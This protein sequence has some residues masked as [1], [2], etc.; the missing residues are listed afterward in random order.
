MYV[1]FSKGGGGMFDKVKKILSPKNKALKTAQ[2]TFSPK[3]IAAGFGGKEAKDQLLKKSGSVGLKSIAK[4]T[5]T[6]SV[7][8]VGA[9]LGAKAIGKSI[10]KKIP[11]VGLLAGIGFGLQR[12]MKGDFAGAALE[13]ASGAVSLVPGVGTAASI[14]I[15]AGL[16]AKDI[17]SASS[18]GGTAADF[19][20]RPGQPIQ[21]FR[22]DDI[23]VG[24]T[25]LSG[26]G[27]NNSEVVSLLQELLLEVKKGG[28]VYMDGNKVGRSLALATSNMG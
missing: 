23:I 17:S 22:K 11:G 20:S 6:K 12:A 8:K 13:L 28:N 9:K 25:S 24:G 1:R 19:I 15:D 2:K 10:L 14:A 16:A 26:G 27:G 18:G 7:A 5:G 21:K 3:Q 4:K